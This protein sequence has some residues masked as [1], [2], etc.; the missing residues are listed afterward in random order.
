M[1]FQ[2]FNPRS[3]ILD[4]LAQLGELSF[5]GRRLNAFEVEAGHVVAHEGAPT[6]RGHQQAVPLELAN[7][8][9]DGHLGYVVLGCQ[10]AKR[11]ELRTWSELYHADSSADVVRQLR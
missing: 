5:D 6:P 3:E 11:R 10:G 9:M 4:R 7:R 2:R 8:S 1:S